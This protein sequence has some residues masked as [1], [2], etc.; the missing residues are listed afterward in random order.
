M[1]QRL[2]ALSRRRFLFAGGAAATAAALVSRTPR[3]PSSEKAADKREARGYRA[4]EHIHNYY[5]TTKV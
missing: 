3:G 1:T 5:R 4:S 2:K